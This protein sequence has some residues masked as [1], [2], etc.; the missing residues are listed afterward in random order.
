[1]RLRQEK[2]VLIVA[3]VLLGFMTWSLMTGETS[4]SRRGSSSRGDAE[5]ETFPAPDLSVSLPS[6]D[7]F[8]VNRAFMARPSD[9]KPLPHLGLVEPPREPFV[10]L[11]PPPIPGPAPRAFGA[12]LRRPLD[13]ELDPETAS[14]LFAE[15]DAGLSDIDYDFEFFQPEED[16]GP[17][18]L[19]DLQDVARL[20]DEER[21]EANPLADLTPQE[22]DLVIAGYK[23]RFDW[24]WSGAEYTWGRIQNPERHGLKTDPARNAE[25]I[26]FVAV[27]PHT[28]EE[29]YGGAPY[30]IQRENVQD[31]DFAATFANEIEVRRRRLS[32]PL[33]RGDYATALELAADCVANRLEAPQALEIAETLYRR[34]AAF[35]P[36]DPAPRL[37]LAR[38]LEA[39]FDFEAAF[40]EYAALVAEFGHRAEPHARLGLLEERFF[41]L[42]EAEASLRRAVAVD[43]GSWEARWSLGGFLARR[44]ELEEALE[45]LTQASRAVPTDPDYLDERIR[46]RL[47][48]ADVHLAL[49]Q[50]PQARG[51]YATL[52][53][54]D[55]EGEGRARARAGWIATEAL[56]TQAM[57]VN[58]SVPPGD[59]STKGFD[60]LLAGGIQA[61]V[62]GDVVVA[63]ESLEAAA[64]TDPI[65]AFAAWRALSY[66]AEV[67]GHPEEA[68]RFIEM[69]LECNPADPWSLYQ[70]G[71]LL[72]DAE[73]FSGARDYFLRALEQELDFEDALASLGE[74]AFK[75]GEFEEAERYLERAVAIAPGRHEVHALR[76]LN[77]L[78]LE[79]VPDARSAFQR[80]SDLTN[81][82]DAICRAGLAWCLYLAGDTEQAMVS[83]RELDDALR[84]LPEDAPI[85]V[86]ALAQ[87]ERIR[88]HEEKVMWSDTFER[89]RILNDWDYRESAGP[90]SRI[91]DGEVVLEGTFE[92]TD[93]SLLYRT[94]PASVFV[95]LEAS[96]WIEPTTKANV[97][98]FLARE[99]ERR[100]GR[101]LLARS[102]VWRHHDGSLQVSITKQ[103]QTPIVADMEEPFPVGQWVRLRI[104][105]AGDASDSRV[106]LFADGVP[107]VEDVSMPSLRASTPVIFG[108]VAEGE[109][110]RTVS[111]KLDD[112]EVVFR[113]VR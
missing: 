107:L 98:I 35:D 43:R 49:G 70:Q 75:L 63:K 99:R 89:K 7:A 28:G 60:V 22:R 61:L 36:E 100:Q 9:T 52:L 31:F 93:G 40:A 57:G 102:A 110:G 39:G 54:L 10:A 69:A 47:D 82:Q 23:K 3:V 108:L 37:G 30:D 16:D 112:V 96:L 103:G 55:P 12:L 38:C 105:R 113:E 53:G 32:D 104:E 111:C 59:E 76:G 20:Q 87:I 66:L 25:P 17:S 29:L 73:D 64:D 13:L 15:A 56:K 26:T 90:Q 62:E 5:L 79:S 85:R 80:G 41:L 86:W 11:L 81:R 6:G 45:H 33:V 24:A 51:L 91:V 2:I 8:V 27:K 68:Q 95:S 19:E 21:S 77:F 72:V 71:R 78:L 106:T 4:R 92:A 50:L 94:L 84:D 83:L 42:E 34:C 1:M 67:T 44:L 97:G 58:G 14:A 101:E 74:M 46:V 88:D 65:R 18:L 48:L 109:P